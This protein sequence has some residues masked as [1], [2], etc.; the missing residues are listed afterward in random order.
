MMTQQDKV[1]PSTDAKDKVSVPADKKKTTFGDRSGS[2]IKWGHQI[3]A[4]LRSL[5]GKKTDESE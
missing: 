5:C 4:Y 3:F 2:E 1:T